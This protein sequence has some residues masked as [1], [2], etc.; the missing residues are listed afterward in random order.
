M[1]SFGAFPMKDLL[2]QAAELDQLFRQKGWRYCF[3]GGIAIQQWGEPRLTSDMDV[4]LLTG[5]GEEE[6]YVDELLSKYE[7]RIPDARSF[8]LQ[9]RVLLLRNSQGTGMDVALGA[10]PFEV[11][12]VDRAHDV[13]FQPAV[14]LRTCTAEDLIVMKAFANRGGDWVDVRTILVRQGVRKLDWDH[15]LRELSPL[16]ELKEEPDIVERLI[17]LKR[18]ISASEPAS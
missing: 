2:I 3:I 18:D 17:R 5:F 13:E 1:V 10:L 12:A 11:L 14:F 15:I 16:C 4:T 7:A 9:N 8:A 6:S